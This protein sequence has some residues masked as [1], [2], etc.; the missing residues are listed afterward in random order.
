MK[1]KTM[2][3]ELH[4]SL[5]YLPDASQS[6]LGVLDLPSLFPIFSPY[7]CQSF[8]WNF[9][10]PFFYNFGLSCSMHP[11]R[12]SLHLVKAYTPGDCLL[13][14]IQSDFKALSNG[15]MAD[16]LLIAYTSSCL[17]VTVVGKVILNRKSQIRAELRSLQTKLVISTLGLGSSKDQRYAI[18]LQFLLSCVESCMEYHVP[19]STNCRR[20]YTNNFYLEIKLNSYKVN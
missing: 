12:P 4:L 7:L 1:I 5:H 2:E 15:G 10:C 18:Y 14:L 13:I 9:Y 11:S 20:K 8:M 16:R 17:I 3:F 19:K 6:P